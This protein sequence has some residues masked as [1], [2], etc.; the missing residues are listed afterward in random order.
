MK[1]ILA[2]P[3]KIST[4]ENRKWIV[5]IC[6][7]FI[8]VQAIASA[9]GGGG[10]GGGSS[11]SDGG[12][13]EICIYI[14]YLIPFP[15]NIIAIGILFLIAFLTRKKVRAISGL[16]KIASFDDVDQTPSELPVD[17]MQRNPEFTQEG[18]NTKVQTAFMAIQDAWMKMDLTGVRKWITDGV[19]Q[20]F[21]TQFLMMQI[22]GQKNIMSDIKVKK[23][24][25]DDVQQ[26]GNYDII[27]VGIHFTMMDNFITEKN[28]DLNT[29]GYLEN[30]EYWTFIRKSGVKEK[31]MFHSENCPSCGAPLPKNMGE[32]GKCENCGVITTLGDY[33]WV[34]S[35]ITQAADY[36]ND[37][38]KLEK[39]GKLTQRIREAMRRDT[40]FSVQFIEDKASNAYMQMLSAE[41]LKKP[42]RMRRFVDA[43]LFEK[44]SEQI[45][46]EPQLAFNRLYL[47]NVTLMDFYQK[48]GKDN[49]V[50]GF[51]RTAQKLTMADGNISRFDYAMYTTNEIMIMSRDMGAGQPKGSLYA[52]SCPSCAGPIADTLDLKCVYCG[53]ELNSTKNEWIITGL[54]NASEYSDIAEEEQ[55]P[56]ITNVGVKDLDPL[57]KVRDYAVNNVMM[58]IFAD[59]KMEESELAFALK[60]MKKL[61]YD[62]KKIGGFISLGQNRQLTLRLPED[63]KSAQK[64]YDIMFKAANADGEIHQTEKLILDDVLAKISQMA[65]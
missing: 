7:A 14:L 36:A 9:G 6:L 31:D 24:L 33:D 1:F 37:N 60:L 63:K 19:W 18:F 10:G 43:A 35:E 61:G 49:M 17:F 51:K 58:I 4:K 15:Y 55:L 22:I 23:V 57:F 44:F 30:V 11:D 5:S 12:I 39:N 62:S 3:G 56:L 29:E 41:V 26:D 21:N 48:Q 25:I 42:E 38:Q 45:K 13:F 65:A 28:P 46:N 2:L 53:A 16:N 50:L 32:V 27:N 20:R 34:L 40:D 59:G 47:N 8:A 64:V 54:M 52:H